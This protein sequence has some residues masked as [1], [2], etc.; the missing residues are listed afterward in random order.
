MVLRVGLPLYGEEI[1]A[2]WTKEVKTMRYQHHGILN[3][4]VVVG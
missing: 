4:D 2:A 3:T 1:A